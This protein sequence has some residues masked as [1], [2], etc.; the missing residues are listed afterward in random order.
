MFIYYVLQRL[1]IISAAA[2]SNIKLKVTLNAVPQ[3][4][5]N[6]IYRTFNINLARSQLCAGGDRGRDSCKGDSGGPIMK[7]DNQSDRPKWY[8][9]GIVSFGSAQCGLANWPGIYTRVDYFIDW[10][11]VTIRD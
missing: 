1:Y 5:C 2:Q 3:A 9:V 8:L 6:S 10:I 4:K 11:L 7:F